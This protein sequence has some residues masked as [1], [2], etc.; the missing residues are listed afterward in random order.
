MKERVDPFQ[1]LPEQET[2]EEEYYVVPVEDV[3]PPHTDEHPVC[4]DPTC[5]CKQQ[6]V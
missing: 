2:D 1:F 4:D 6:L 3:D 5:P